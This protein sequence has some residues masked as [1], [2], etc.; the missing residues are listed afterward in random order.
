VAPAGEAEERVIAYLV[1]C[2]NVTL[3]VPQFHGRLAEPPR[4]SV[5]GQYRALLQVR[6][7][8]SGI[9][10]RTRLTS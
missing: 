8:L 1:T 3:M 9:Q 4:G 5:E 2:P 10:P 6:L 7:M